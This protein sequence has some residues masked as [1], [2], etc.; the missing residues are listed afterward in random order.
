VAAWALLALLSGAAASFAES[1]K[2]TI[3]CASQATERQHC[4]ADT[5]SGVTFGDY[6]DH[7]M[8]ATRLG[9]P[10]LHSLISIWR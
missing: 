6:F 7:Q 4:P 5:S 1:R 8:V 10:F 3:A 9:A 2:G